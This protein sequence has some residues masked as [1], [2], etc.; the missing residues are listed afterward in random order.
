M[1]KNIMA[2]MLMLSLGTTAL[3]GVTLTIEVSNVTSQEGKLYVG[4]YSKNQ[5]FANVEG[6]FLKKIVD[7]ISKTG[8]IEVGFDEV[9]EGEYALAIFHD[10]NSNDT[11]D[12]NF[13]GFPKEPFAFSNNFKPKFSEPEFEDCSFVLEKE[14]KSLSLVLID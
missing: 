9:E 5:E 11:L 13:I 14:G 12:K 7:P 2:L 8:A 3:L 10:R 1:N 4:L 6:A